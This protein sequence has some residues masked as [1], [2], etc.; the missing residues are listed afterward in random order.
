MVLEAV[1]KAEVSRVKG[2]LKGAI[3]LKK[4]FTGVG[5]TVLRVSI[6]GT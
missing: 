3:S 4:P 1:Y 5:N 6:E 2:P